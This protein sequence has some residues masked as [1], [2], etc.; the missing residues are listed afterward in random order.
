MNAYLTTI[1]RKTGK[2]RRV[3]LYAWPDADRFVIVGSKGGAARD[4]AWA[5]NLRAEPRA[6]LQVGKQ[7]LAVRATEATGGERERL[8]GL[9]TEAFRYYAAY[10]RRTKRLIPLFVLER[11]NGAERPEPA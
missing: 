5:H 11:A 9:V 8:W 3:R 1:G 2:E 7:V 6:T 10:Q 4:P